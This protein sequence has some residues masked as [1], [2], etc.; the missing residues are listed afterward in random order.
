MHDANV[1]ILLKKSNW[2][3]LKIVYIKIMCWYV[4]IELINTIDTTVEAA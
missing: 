4:P 1:V 2:E 3:S